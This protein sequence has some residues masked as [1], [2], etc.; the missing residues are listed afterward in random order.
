MPAEVHHQLLIFPTIDLEVTLVSYIEFKK[1]HCLGGP[2]GADNCLTHSCRSSNIVDIWSDNPQ[3]SLWGIG[4]L[5]C[6]SACPSWVPAGW[7]WENW[8]NQ[9]AWSSQHSQEHFLFSH[10]I[11]SASFQDNGTGGWRLTPLL[12]LV[13]PALFPPPATRLWLLSLSS[14]FWWYFNCCLPP[15]LSQLCRC[16]RTLHIDFIWN[17]FTQMIFHVAVLNSNTASTQDTEHWCCN[18]TSYCATQWPRWKPIH[19]HSHTPPLLILSLFCFTYTTNF[20]CFTSFPLHPP[21]CLH[22]MNTTIL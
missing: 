18:N 21:K 5:L 22:H 14:H 4:H 17:S 13:Q 16:R 8:R 11:S 7:Y 9:R 20:F 10:F 3:S 19:C 6:S 15:S 2:Y 1:Y 12:S